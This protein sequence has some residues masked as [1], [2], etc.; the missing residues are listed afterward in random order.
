MNK[1]KDFETL[2]SEHYQSLYKLAYKLAGSRENA[3]DIVQE[4]F[5]KAYANREKFRGDASLYPC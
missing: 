4:A 2:F 5:L 3:D 1:L